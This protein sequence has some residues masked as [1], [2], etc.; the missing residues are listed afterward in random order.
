MIGRTV[1]RAQDLGAAGIS[2]AVSESAAR[3]TWGDLDLDAVPL[4][5]RGLEA[6]EI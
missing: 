1:G 5:E 6:F 3:A 4:R 2:C